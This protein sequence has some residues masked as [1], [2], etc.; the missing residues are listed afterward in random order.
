MLRKA[1]WWRGVAVKHL[2]SMTRM[3]VAFFL[4]FEF[5][6]AFDFDIFGFVAFARI[7]ELI[8]FLL[9]VS[10]QRIVESF[11]GRREFVAS[12]VDRIR[13]PRKPPDKSS[14]SILRRVNSLIDCWVWKISQIHFGSKSSVSNSSTDSFR[15]MLTEST[16]C[17]PSDPQRPTKLRGTNS[18]GRYA[19]NK[20]RWKV[21]SLVS[22]N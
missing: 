12:F 4:G 17:A 2:L 19:K 6:G 15:E 16:A 11:S 10:S 21:G 8:A 14:R 9:S 1:K 7:V 18:K 3:I 22:S 5:G 13:P 20:H